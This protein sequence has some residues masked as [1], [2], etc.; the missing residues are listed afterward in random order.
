MRGFGMI[1]IEPFVHWIHLMAA[2]VW[3]GGMLF[4]A[5]VFAPV[6]RKEIPPQ[7]RGPLF[8][9]VGKRFSKVGWIALTLLVSTGFYKIV[10]GWES[11][12]TFLSPYGTIL[13]AKIFLVLIVALLSILHDFLWGPR[14][15][16][17]SLSEMD[18]YEFKRTLSR[19]TFWA[20][21]NV[22]LVVLILFL[23]AY[24]RMN[25]F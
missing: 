25:P 4:T 11:W 19:L 20:R 2:T 14:L 12:E 17:F 3:V 8:N 22:F 16:K 1:L 21:V 24:L 7:I 23:A 6:A 10:S 9:K 15:A 5:I 18:S 13:A